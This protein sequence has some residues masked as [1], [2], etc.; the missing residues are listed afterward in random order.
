LTETVERTIFPAMNSPIYIL[1][2][3]FLCA[4]LFGCVGSTGSAASPEARARQDF[5]SRIN[6]D[7]PFRVSFSAQG[8]DREL[9]EITVLEKVSAY[10]A[11]D[12]VWLILT[13]ELKKDAKRL[14]FTHIRIK[15]G[16]SS[17]GD[18]DTINKTVDL[19]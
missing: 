2:I 16:R 6:Q 15:G 4:L 7:Y 9:L 17:F 1:L 11:D 5:A 10:G 3:I 8:N 18:P 19:R 13:D 12:T 14:K